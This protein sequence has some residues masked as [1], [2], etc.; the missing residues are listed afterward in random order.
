MSKFN[1]HHAV[2]PIYDAAARWREKCLE[3]N[4]SVM[5]EGKSS[6][7]LTLLNE[8]DPN[9]RA[10]RLAADCKA[11]YRP[12]ATRVGG[13]SRLARVTSSHARW[14]RGD[15]APSSSAPNRERLLAR[16]KG[17]GSPP[18]RR[19][20]RSQYELLSFANKALLLVFNGLSPS[21]R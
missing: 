16:G 10:R 20:L 8:L 4:K 14:S 19:K 1:P 2:N 3:A 18:E 13:L 15:G 6:W 21:P 5:A 11:C 12:Q 7:T 9:S 17:L